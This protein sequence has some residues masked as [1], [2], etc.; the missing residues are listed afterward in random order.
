MVSGFA[1]VRA[2]LYVRSIAISY[3][4]TVVLGDVLYGPYR[5]DVKTMLFDLQL[6]PC[7]QTLLGS[8]VQKEGV[9]GEEGQALA[10]LV[11]LRHQRGRHLRHTQGVNTEHPQGHGDA[12]AV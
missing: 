11:W 12:A 1:A 10:V 9:R 8:R 2:P 3:V 5:V 6:W 4:L 7:T